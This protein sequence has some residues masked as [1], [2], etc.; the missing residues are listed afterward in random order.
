[1]SLCASRSANK[2][3]RVAKFFRT[4]DKLVTFFRSN[5]KRANHL[6]DNLPKPGDTRWLSRDSAI[7]VIVNCY[8]TI[9]TVLFE[10][11]NYRKEKAETQSLSRGLGIQMQEIE[12]IFLLYRKLFKYCTPMI[13]VM[14]RPTLDPVVVKSMLNDFQTALN[15]FDFNQIWEDSILLDPIIPTVRARVVWR[16][17]EPAING[18]E[19]WKISLAELGRE[20]VTMFL[21][22]IGWRFSNL[23]KFKW[24]NLVHP[25]KFSERKFATSSEQ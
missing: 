21:A 17:M 9:G 19:N 12:F 20:I 7:R 3:P 1:M 8:G 2:I 13:T 11:T 24:V 22:Q 10:I 16:N 18:T 23:D 15:H 14:Q 25:T 5:P 6:G 4:T